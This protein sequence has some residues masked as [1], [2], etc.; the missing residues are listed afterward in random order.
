[1]PYGA[2]NF[3][4]EK[5]IT[6]LQNYLSFARVSHFSNEC[7]SRGYAK[8]ALDLVGRF[9]LQIMLRGQKNSRGGCESAM[10][11]AMDSKIDC[12]WRMNKWNKMIFCM[13]IQI[14]KDEKPIKTVLS[15]HETLKLTVFQK[16]TGFKL[17]FSMQYKF[18]KT[19]SWFSDF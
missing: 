19:A 5:N 15:G 11:D 4:F 8:S 7:S 6:T 12:I 13:L 14:H 17:I 1:M 3:N 9:F 10:D 18:R 16:W 2:F